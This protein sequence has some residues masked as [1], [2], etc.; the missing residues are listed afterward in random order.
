MHRS[1][2]TSELPLNHWARRG[3]AIIHPINCHSYLHFL[4]PL[5]T[6]QKDEPSEGPLSS[7]CHS[8]SL[9]RYVKS[10][11]ILLPGLFEKPLSF[12]STAAFSKK[13]REI[14]EIYV[15]NASYECEYDWSGNYVCEWTDDTSLGLILG[16]AIAIPLIILI[17]C[18]I[19]CCCCC[20]NCPMYRGKKDAPVIIM[21]Q[22]Q[23]YPMGPNGQPAYPQQGYGNYPG[24]P[25]GPPNY[26]QQGYS[27]YPADGQQGPP[28][29]GNNAAP[30]PAPAP[31]WAAQERKN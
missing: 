19:G 20:A 28:Q 29:R 6:S 9:P 30:H 27:N 1:L 13:G 8:I 10:D 25:Q 12:P 31:G 15:C 24:S 7:V 4:C 18:I 11:G 5:P 17:A 26:P 14:I 16:L 3:S 2:S 23:M 21:P 22:Q